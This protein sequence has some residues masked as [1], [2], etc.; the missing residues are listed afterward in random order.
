MGKHTPD[1]AGS[2][3]AYTDFVDRAMG[4]LVEENTQLRE[5]RDEL[6]RACR[7]AGIQLE[8][9]ELI[10]VDDAGLNPNAAFVQRLRDTMDKLKEAL[11][12]VKP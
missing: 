11:E 9:C 8:V 6:T 1:F 2:L 5:Q 7:S 10:V 3:Q 4:H 12:K